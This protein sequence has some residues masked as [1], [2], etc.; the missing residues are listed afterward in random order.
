MRRRELVAGLGVSLAVWPR[1]ALAQQPVTPIVAF[2]GMAPGS[3]NANR[4]EGLRSGLR[5]LGYIEGNNVVIELR[6]AENPAHLPELA[7]EL[8]RREVAIVIGSGN[9]ATRAAQSASSRIPILFAAADDPVRLGF[10]ASFNRPGG[11]ITG[12]SLI[13]GALGPKRFELLREIVP[14]ARNIAVLTNPNNPAQHSVRG[15]QETARSTGLSIIAVRCQHRSRDPAG[16]YDH[17]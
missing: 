10:V 1:A 11:N 5:E 14:Q 7:T 16:L 17:G 15:E 13:S 2:L 3:A 4:V 8:S 9:A 12:L 6:F